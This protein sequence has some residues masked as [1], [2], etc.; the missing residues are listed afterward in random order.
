MYNIND[1][2]SNIFLFFNTK[3]GQ[4]NFEK[5]LNFIN[6]LGDPHL[7]YYHFIFILAIA[8]TLI[9]KN[10]NKPSELNNLV[11]EGIISGLTAILALIIGLIL[12]VN[13]LKAYTSVDRP[14]CSL[15]DIFTLQHVIE[16]ST[17]NHSFPSG[18]AAYSVIMIASFWPLLNR[19][20][21]FFAAIFL[22]LLLISRMASGAHYPVDL[23]GAVIICL[24]LTL[25]TRIKVDKY[26][27]Y[28]ELKYNFL[29]KIIK[30]T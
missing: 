23:F 8:S 29:S 19:F 1:F 14:H 10:K 6:A 28:Y 16:T 27:K 7:F 30:A 2:N 18:H 4:P 21:K 15:N 3:F 17:C 11:L 13:I 26:I 9:Y 5:Y 20:F 25:Y 24:P 22:C 12:T